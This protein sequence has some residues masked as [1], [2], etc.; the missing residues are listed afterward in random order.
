MRV[1]ITAF[2]TCVH[3]V[4]TD[5]FS[6]TRTQGNTKARFASRIFYEIKVYF[7]PQNQQVTGNTS[8]KQRIK[9]ENERFIHLLTCHLSSDF[10]HGNSEEEEGSFK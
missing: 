4:C 7:K 2:F 8:E 9:G 6:F 1:P 10:Y 3:R 5:K